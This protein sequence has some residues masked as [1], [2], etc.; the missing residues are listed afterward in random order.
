[1]INDVDNDNDDEYCTG[2]FNENQSRN[3]YLS[4]YEHE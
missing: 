2:E 1:M 4:C 3:G